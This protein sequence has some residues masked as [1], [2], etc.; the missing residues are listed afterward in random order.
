M[1]I[2]IVLN[3]SLVPISVNMES[4]VNLLPPWK[5]K[6]SRISFSYYAR[7]K[8]NFTRFQWN[9]NNKIFRVTVY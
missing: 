6:K 8:F 3:K 4:H 5:F 2:P 7:I 9:I 1:V